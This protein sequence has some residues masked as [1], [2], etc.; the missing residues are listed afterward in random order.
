M[1]D[2]STNNAQT[3]HFLSRVS[4]VSEE[5]VARITAK[6][7][8]RGRGEFVPIDTLLDLLDFTLLH[9]VCVILI[10]V[11]VWLIHDCSLGMLWQMATVM[12]SG[13][14]VAMVGMLLEK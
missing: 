9:E 7:A 11:T 3:K 4:V 2:F 14:K 5:I 6:N 13:T 8:L 10:S 12:M 1:L